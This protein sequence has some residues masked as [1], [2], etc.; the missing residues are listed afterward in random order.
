MPNN[1]KYLEVTHSEPCPF[2]RNLHEAHED[3]ICVMIYHP[4][5][6]YDEFYPTE[7]YECSI[8]GYATIEGVPNYCPNCGK[9]VGACDNGY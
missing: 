1:E 2:C 4:E 3:D 9:K 8:C 5:W 6:S 7:A